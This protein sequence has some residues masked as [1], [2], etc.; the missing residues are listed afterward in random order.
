MSE[1][2]YEAIVNQLQAENERLRVRLVQALKGPDI[3][4]DLD[5]I[6]AWLIEN[7]IVIGG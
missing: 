1:I 6:R 4:I 5:A 3:V 2:D 7:Y